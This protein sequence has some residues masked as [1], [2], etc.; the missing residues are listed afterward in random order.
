MPIEMSRYCIPYT[1]F[2]GR[3]EESTLCL[4][5]N[6][7]VYAEGQPPFDLEGDLSLRK[8]PSDV[9]SGSLR[10]AHDHYN[11]SDADQDANLVFPVDRLRELVAEKKIGALTTEFIGKGF[12]TAMREIKERVAWEIA[13]EVDRL[14]PDIVLL[15]GG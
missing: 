6:A 4:V 13:K 9:H 2:R 11:H 7:G 15:T 5:S 1:P 10:I 12:S 3:L 8:I 14:R